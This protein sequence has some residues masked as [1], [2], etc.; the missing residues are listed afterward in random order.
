MTNLLFQSYAGML[1]IVNRFRG[2]SD[3]ASERSAEGFFR[4]IYLAHIQRKIR[5]RF[6]E[7]RH[8]LKVFDAGCGYGRLAIPL[9]RA[10][11]DV[12]G[13][14]SSKRAIEQARESAE[15]ADVSA[16]FRCGELSDVLRETKEG[17]FDVVLCLEV[18]TWLVNYRAV[19]GA[20]RRILA[21]GG[22]LFV[23]FQPAH[24]FVTTLLRQRKFNAARYVTQHDEGLL[25]IAT[26]PT[27][28]NWPETEEIARLHRS[29]GLTLLGT[30]PI[31]RYCGFDRDG[32]AGIL[33][34]E[35]EQV[36]DAYP[37]LLEIE[38]SLK[39]ASAK[40]CRHSLF[41]STA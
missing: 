40:H 12:T 16:D 32:V 3:A 22:L 29:N 30:V 4:D 31:G 20:L 25:R 7:S 39:D 21:P 11:H 9:S 36:R 5:E 14:D 35:E 23:T 27:Y 19:F 15:K 8:N 24:Y 6:G 33:D 41:V 13:V 38:L 17:S 34:L 28:Y 10:G 26:A 1:G 2:A 37:T 18:L